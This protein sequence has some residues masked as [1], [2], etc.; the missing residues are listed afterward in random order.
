MA[1]L[2]GMTSIADRYD[3]SA[4]RYERWWAPVLAP[5]ALGLLDTIAAELDAR[6]EA[7]VLDV[8]TGS[9]TLALGV[10]ERWPHVS[11]VGVD[12]SAGMLDVARDRTR[13]R[14]GRL[15]DRLTLVRAS[16]GNLP[17]EDASF[18]LVV[19]SFVLQLVPDRR[20]ALLESRRVLRPRGLLAVMTWLVDDRLFEPD[21][22]FEDALD[23][24][25]VDVPDDDE[26]PRSGNFESAAAAAAQARRAGFRDVR[27]VAGELV[28]RYE[29]AEYLEFLEE[30]AE[31]GVFEGLEPADRSRLRELTAAR[32]GH[33]SR[34]DF[35]WRAGVV[36]LLGRRP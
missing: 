6:P 30:Y 9:G 31:R 34:A 2:Q 29:P 3:Y 35:V 25:A 20:A 1:R 24:L 22:A 27:A 21:E 7:R 17:V 4:G 13:Q 10:L 33:L 19:S 32:L 28:H 26:E 15:A 18:D 14:L 12:S 36:T 5:T 8:G 11:V 16:A 23:D